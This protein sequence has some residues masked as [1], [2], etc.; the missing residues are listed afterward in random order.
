MK[1]PLL[2]FTLSLFITLTNNSCIKRQAKEKVLIFGT[3]SCVATFDPGDS[4]DGETGCKMENLFEGLVQFKPGTIEIEPCLATS[5]EISEDGKEIIFNL[6]KNVKFHD[7]TDFNAD[8]VVF[9]LSR[10]YDKSHPFHNYGRWHYWKYMFTDIE[11]VEKLDEYKVK[12]ILKNINA[13]I[14]TSL[15][16]TAVN[17]VSPTNHIEYKEEAYKHPC[18]TGPFKFVEW[19]KGEHIT[20]KAND[21]YWRKRANIEKLIFKVI[22]NSEARYAAL[23]SNKIQGMEYPNPEDFDKIRKNP[24]LKLMQEP[25]MNVGFMAINTG[26]GYKD[27][28]KNN[29]KDSYE[30]W[31]KTPGYHEP[32]TK[33]KVRKAI[34]HSIDKQSI[35][36]NIY[37][38]TA[39]PAINGIPP[40]MLGYNDKIVDY[41]YNPEKAKKLLEEA[42]YPDGFDVTLYV[43]PISRPY[44]P[45]PPKIG[46][47]IQYYLH[48]IGINVTF[49]QIEWETYND[50]VKKG[51]AQMCLLGWT[52]DNG[53]PDNFLNTLC[54]A[55]RCSLGEGGNFSFY[56]NMEAQALLTKAIQTYDIVKRAK[57]YYKFQEMVHENASFVYLAHSVQSVAFRRNVDG[58]VLNPTASQCFYQVKINGN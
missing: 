28:N 22:P 21:N 20:L 44:M 15:A 49:Y 18:G 47:A 24:N 39:I 23:D 50:E 12:F 45:D 25:G 17:I 14:M 32:L 53:D 2:I 54:G 8:A 40:R 57:Y 46:E 29:K 35:I 27:K 56:N 52:G 16:L 43:M 33:K 41:E 26:Y 10:M 37:Q 1:N 5:W 6:R 31:I 48:E 36:D 34:Q 58:F 55:N 7:G 51:K 38:G 13:S 19:V 3:N 4:Y 30:Q 42:G 11:K 9:S